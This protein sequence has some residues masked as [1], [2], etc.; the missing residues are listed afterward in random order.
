MGQRK[1]RA[2]IPR[3]CSTGAGYPGQR[4]SWY[5]ATAMTH[6]L[7]ALVLLLSSA[8]AFAVD[9]AS[10]Y[11]VNA[12]LPGQ[13]TIEATADAGFGWIRYDFNWF[14]LEPVNDQFQWAATDA[15]VDAAVAEGLNVFATLAYT[16]RGPR[17]TRAPASPAA[18]KR[19]AA[20]RAPSPTSPTGRI[21]STRS[22]RATA[23]A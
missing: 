9:P 12:H 15:A 20:R 10:P 18:R 22:S 13:A 2:P 16:R 6:R 4:I 23:I 21:S 3:G 8:P 7:A 19:I 1:G 5:D 11:G 14:Q 17:P